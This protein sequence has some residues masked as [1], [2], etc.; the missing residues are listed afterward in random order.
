MSAG[1]T[2]FQRMHIACYCTGSFVNIVWKNSI[3]SGDQAI[4]DSYFKNFK[5]TVTASQNNNVSVKVI[6]YLDALMFKKK[7]Q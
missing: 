5:N 4:N 6:Y 3:F 2:K 1:F 7:H